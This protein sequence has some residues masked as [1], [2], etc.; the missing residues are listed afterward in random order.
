MFRWSLMVLI[1]MV[2]VAFGC[3][4]SYTTD[5]D[6][7]TTWEGD[8]DDTGDDDTGD[9]DTGDDDT[10]DDDT[11]DDDTGDDD[12]GDDDDSV[13]SCNDWDPIDVPGAQWV[14]SS[15]YNI[16]YQ[17]QLMSD[18]GVET[19]QAGGSTYFQGFTVYQRTG[20]FAG[21][22]YQV[23]W[24]GYDNCEAGGNVDYGSYV[25]DSQAQATVL[26]VNSDPVMY[27]PYNPDQQMGY[28]WTSSY[29]QQVDL[30]IE[31]SGT[32]PCTWNWTVV[33]IES[34]SVPAGTFNT[35]IHV[36]ATYQT[37]DPAGSHS[38]TLDTYWVKGLGLV[39]WDEQRPSEGGTYILRELQSYS[40][41]TPQ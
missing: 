38:G 39:K 24:W 29:N 5:D 17:D 40:G 21:A 4:P 1:A 8:D 30:S 11:G 18:S 37:Q 34:V 16:T 14:Y 6:D 12:T 28:S 20:S 35:A 26:T 2:L 13:S 25:T 23:S 7:D 15:N 9:D 32:D 27:L 33:G 10:G 19:V 36:S 41:L 31:G 3:A 22:Q